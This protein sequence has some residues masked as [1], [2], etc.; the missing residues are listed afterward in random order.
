MYQVEAIPS[1]GTGKFDLRAAKAKAVKLAAAQ[2]AIHTMEN[3][4]AN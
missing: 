2:T 4:H 1:L 3:A